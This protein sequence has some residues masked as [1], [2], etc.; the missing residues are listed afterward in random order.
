[1]LLLV[2]L[3]NVW[4]APSGVDLDPFGGRWQWSLA[5][6]WRFGVQSSV[7]NARVVVVVAQH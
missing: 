3:V 7:A 4:C 6:V 5:V 1:M 2:E